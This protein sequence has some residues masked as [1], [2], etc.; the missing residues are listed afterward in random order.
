M[1]V[2]VCGVVQCGEGKKSQLVLQVA[3]GSVSRD[4]CMY[5]TASVSSF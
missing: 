1:C 3:Y 5:H 2:C 4:N